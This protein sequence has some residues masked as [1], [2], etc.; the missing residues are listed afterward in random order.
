MPTSPTLYQGSAPNM[1]SN[2]HHQASPTTTEEHRSIPHE[3]HER[4]E[5]GRQRSV[6][7]SPHQRYQHYG[8]YPTGRGEWEQQDVS[9]TT[10]S[11]YHHVTIPLPTSRSPVHMYD[12]TAMH[13][14]RDQTIQ[15]SLP[16]VQPQPP[17]SRPIGSE[18]GGT[19][20]NA[21]AYALRMTPS[22]IST[23]TVRQG[24]ASRLPISNPGT[25]QGTGG[26][27]RSTIRHAANIGTKSRHAPAP[28]KLNTGQS[29]TTSTTGETKATRRRRRPNESYF[30]IILK[31]IRSSPLQRLKLS[32]IYEFVSREI[33]HMNGD[34]K[35]WQ[36]TVRHNLSHNKCFR[37]IVITDT[38]LPPQGSA[39]AEDE[40][41]PTGSGIPVQPQQPSQQLQ[42][43][44]QTKKGRGGFWV[45]VPKHIEESMPLSRPKKSISEK[46]QYQQKQPAQK[47]GNSMVGP[48]STIFSQEQQL[49][50]QEEIEAEAEPSQFDQST[51]GGG[52][53]SSGSVAPLA[54]MD[55]GQDVA[56]MIIAEQ[57]V[58]SLDH[59]EFH[60]PASFR[61]SH[62]SRNNHGRQQKFTTKVGQKDS[63]GDC[64]SDDE[65]FSTKSSHADGS[66]YDELDETDEGIDVDDEEEEDDHDM[67]GAGEILSDDSSLMDFE[68]EQKDL[69]LDNK[70]TQMT[71]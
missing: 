1:I 40:S 52:S 64:G 5:F 11:H 28:T 48:S 57:D 31:A 17:I 7:G 37:R 9:M 56:S 13:L 59:S 20:T 71:R 55:I 24:S 65:V 16:S 39:E 36:N 44:Q 15:M 50:R 6:S 18:Y 70:A 61:R 47:F 58:S 32:E 41:R 10:A 30:N 66:E 19:F 14:P 45:L 3:Y 53:S 54:A 34:D 8:Q 43:P 63:N 68:F 46:E 38:E 67:D 62:Q 60:P 2:C 27:G 12:Q 42:Q 49:Q 29:T 23:P 33:P 35:G 21:T 22:I 4:N 25:A 26:T 69:D 51:S